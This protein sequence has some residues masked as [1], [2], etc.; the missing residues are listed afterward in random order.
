MS[1][2]IR[3]DIGMTRDVIPEHEPRHT[4]CAWRQLQ[5]TSPIR[6]NYVEM[7]SSAGSSTSIDSLHDRVG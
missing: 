5:S 2:P 1:T 3:T 7:R 4:T 6:H